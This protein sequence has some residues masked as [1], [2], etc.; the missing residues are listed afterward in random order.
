MKRSLV[1]MA[2]SCLILVGCGA[3]EQRLEMWQLT[4]LMKL[5]SG[6]V[7]FTE[8]HEK[9]G[10]P[11]YQECT[12]MLDR[13]WRYTRFDSSKERKAGQKIWHRFGVTEP[14]GAR[15]NWFVLGPSRER[16]AKFMKDAQ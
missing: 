14:E 6:C 5:S 7:E 12:D 11:E 4:A 1:A 16:V 9:F 2:V 3:K 8:V 15:G 10:A 13:K